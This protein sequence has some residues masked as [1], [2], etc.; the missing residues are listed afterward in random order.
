MEIKVLRDVLAA[1]ELISEEINSALSL[2]KVLAVNMMSSPGSGKTTIVARTIE[3]LKS[4]MEI[5]VIAGDVA[6]TLDAERL[7]AHSSN[8]V[9]I[10]TNV[11]G[12]KCHLEAQWVNKALQSFSLQELDLLLIENVGNLICPSG[13]NLGEHLRVIVLS[14]TEGEDKPV[15]YPAMFSRA[16]AVIINKIDLLPYLDFDMAALGSHLKKVASNAK[17]FEM[18]AKT[19]QGLTPWFDWLRAQAKG[20][21]ERPR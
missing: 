6:T 16:H 17:P 5:G 20:V 11:F 12:G 10:D 2:N 7:S 21:R 13:F 3:A 9:Q 15:K 19:G 1:N 14:V 8:V 18:S 4:E